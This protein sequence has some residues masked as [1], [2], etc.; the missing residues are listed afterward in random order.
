MTDESFVTARRFA[1][2][3]AAAFL[4]AA[5]S[6]CATIREYIPTIPPPSFGWL[7]SDKKPGPLP[8]LSAS[9]TARVAWQAP[10]GRAAPGF[11]PAVLADAIYAASSDGTIARIEPASG[12][13]VWRINANRRLSAGVGADANVIAVGTD[14]GDV[15]AFDTNGK[16]LWTAR[17][18]TEVIAP[19]RVAEGLVIVFSGDGNVHALSAADGTRKWVYQRVS[20]PLTVRNYAGGTVARGALFV[21]TAG[22]RLLAIDVA[23]GIVGWDATV[24]SPRGATELERIA[25]VTSLPTLDGALAC[26]VAYQGR[27]A[28]FDLARGT[29]NWSRDVSSLYGMVADGSHLYVT[30]ERGA[31]HA[32]DKTTGASVWKQDKLAARK[33]GG[34]QL[35]GEHVG[36]VDVQGFLHVLAR[37][38][39]AY[40]GRVA[41][42]GTAATSQPLALAG[43]A[44]WL[45][46]GGTLFAV[47]VQ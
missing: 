42:D 38:N 45:S 23:T 24:A 43:N 7:W 27:L 10:V 5:F 29:L 9:V 44:L 4:L 12:R 2:Y 15:V 19:P 13:I 18:S 39:G 37:V 32:L 28:C 47:T 21:G 3:G 8:E 31:V 17:V 20:P 40:V 35:I 1:R 22:G 34:P 26:A 46:A 14:K 16:Q 6:G 41:T 11:A 33:P 30:D 25:D 36:V